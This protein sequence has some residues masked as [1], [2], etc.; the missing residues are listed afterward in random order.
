MRVCYCGSVW[1]CTAATLIVGPTAGLLTG[2]AFKFLDNIAVV[3]A[4]MIA[5]LSQSALSILF[6]GLA[7]RVNFLAGAFLCILAL[8]TYYLGLPCLPLPARKADSA[9]T[10]D[11]GSTARLLDAQADSELEMEGSTGMSMRRIADNE[12][13]AD[14]SFQ[15]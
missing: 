12:P 13:A 5:M 3:F 10:H 14:R 2:A 11:I 6:F 9:P 1:A 4:D 7:I 15:T 8:W